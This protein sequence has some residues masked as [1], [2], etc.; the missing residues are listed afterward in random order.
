MTAPY[1]PPAMG[2]I[3]L[4]SGPSTATKGVLGCFLIGFMLLLVPLMAFI[5]GTILSA[6]PMAVLVLLVFWPSLFWA[7][8]RLFR[9]AAWLEGTTLVVQGAFTARRSDLATSPHIVLDSVPETTTVATGNASLTMHTGRRIPRLTAYDSARRPV[10]VH[11][12]DSTGRRWL[13]PPKLHALADAILAGPRPE[14][15]A[16][17]AMWVVS[18]LRAM[19]GDPTGQIR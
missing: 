18:G 4:W 12:I 17:Q 15:Q 19:A 3:E 9:A 7:V 13:P 8:M 1:L 14:P 5:A 6:P 2:R 10:R 16:G 11:L